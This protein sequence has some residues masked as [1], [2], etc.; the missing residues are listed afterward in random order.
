MEIWRKNKIK[1]VYVYIDQNIESL[2]W[3]STKTKAFLFDLTYTTLHRSD[4]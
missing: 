2:L 4:F 1:K 3:I